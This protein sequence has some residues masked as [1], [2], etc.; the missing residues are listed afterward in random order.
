[1]ARFMFG[2]RSNPPEVLD[3]DL[4]DAAALTVGLSATALADDK[5]ISP[6][7]DKFVPTLDN[8]KTIRKLV[9]AATT[10]G[11]AAL[12]RIGLGLVGQHRWGKWGQLGGTGLGLGRAVTA[13]VPN[14]QLSATTP[15][16]TT[17]AS[18]FGGT[19]AAPAALA[20]GAAASGAGT[21]VGALTG[22]GSPQ[23]SPDVSGVPTSVSQAYAIGA[24]A[25]SLKGGA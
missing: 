12:Y 15:F 7:I 21:G 18:I 22:G 10:V 11:T 3:V 20:A 9:D 2:H 13:F 19:A 6:L 1:M 17:V 14:Y 4:E 16:D 8:N 5:I 23:V 25:Y 24:P